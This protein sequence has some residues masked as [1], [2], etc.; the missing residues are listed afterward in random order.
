M[1]HRLWMMIYYI[2]HKIPITMTSIF[3][4][5]LKFRMSRVG[6]VDKVDAELRAELT[7]IGQVRFSDM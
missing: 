1:A 3:S 5:C 2:S 7:A 6:W 4:N